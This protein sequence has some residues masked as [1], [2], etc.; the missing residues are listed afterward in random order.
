MKKIKEVLSLPYAGLGYRVINNSTGIGLGSVSHYIK[1]A[2]ACGLTWPLPADL[3]DEM[4]QEC[5]FPK[6]PVDPVNQESLK[7]GV[8]YKKIHT[9]LKRKGGTLLL[10][11][12]EYKAAH[13]QGYSYSQFC[14]LYRNHAKQLTPSMRLTHHAGEKMFVD[15]SGLTMPWIDKETGVIHCAEIF[16]A[17]LGSS[18]YTYVEAC[19]AQSIIEWIKAHCHALEFF[20]GVPNCI[21]PDNLKSGVTKT[22]RY[23]ADIQSTYQELANHYGCAIVPACSYRPKDKSKV[24]VGVQGIQRWVLAPLRDMTFFSIAQIN[25]ALA[26]LL[27]AYNERHFQELEGSRSSQYEVL[28]QPALKALPATRYSFAQWKTVRAGI[29][30]HVTFD[31]HHYSIS[32][33][34]LKKTIELRVTHT[35]LS[36]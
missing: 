34:Y 5:L 3:N 23:D 6:E 30:Y 10:L 8:D 22:H 25:Q 21:V 4:L 32:H 28:E 33:Q 9:E 2:K 1:R 14:R 12:Y 31:K 15:Y 35:T 20:Q 18:N 7:A 11:W 26:P 27:K 29:D 16:V 17:V 24:E 36:P 13:P 19:A